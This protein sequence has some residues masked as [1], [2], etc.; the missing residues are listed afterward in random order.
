[1]H[2]SNEAQDTVVFK[3]GADRQA[4]KQ[5]WDLLTWI[6]THLDDS[7]S[8]EM[9][10]E[11]ADMSIRQFYRCFERIAGEPPAEHIQRLRLAAG[12]ALLAYSDA[13]VVQAA[14]AAGYESREAFT[15]IFTR[16]Y[17]CTPKAFRQIMRRHIDEIAQKPV[18]VQLSIVGIQTLPTYRVA[19]WPHLGHALSSISSWLKL[20][21][22]ARPRKQLGPDAVP[23]SVLYDDGSVMPPGSQER[24]D[25][26]L[27]I[28]KD[29]EADPEE[30]CIRYEI[31]GGT[32][33][34]AR[35][36]GAVGELDAAWDYFGMV[37][38]FESGFQLR[39][40]R[41]L[42]LHEPGD[43]PTGPVQ[44]AKILAG[45]KISCRFCIPVDTV[46][47][48]NLPIVHRMHNKVLKRG[49]L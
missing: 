1:M 19:A 25:A 35:Y 44:I 41:F 26:A 46:A 40:S 22:W 8:V 30:E 12:A 31:A 15:R 36:E 20:G 29:A 11:K 48:N 27:V 28:D 17:G 49:A 37:W 21:L 4:F 24:Y 7:I 14:V 9:L 5:I 45:K 6:R 2:S 38:F 34:V 47:G 33:A 43:I 16:H 42:V 39:D 18:P 3:I 32:F 10:A 23:I 13:T